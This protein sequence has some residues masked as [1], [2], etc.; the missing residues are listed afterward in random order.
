MPILVRCPGCGAKYRISDSAA[1]RSFRCKNAGC[2]EEISVPEIIADEDD[3][4][5]NLDEAAADFGQPVPAPVPASTPKKTPARREKR[6]LAASWPA[7]AGCWESARFS[8][9]I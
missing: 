1:G 5:S 9:R 8:V 3:F 7:S 4:A 2:G 6:T